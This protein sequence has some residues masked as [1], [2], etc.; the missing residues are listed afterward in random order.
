M[1]L[2]DDILNT[3]SW[4]PYG[5]MVS[6]ETEARR[7]FKFMREAIL[8][9]HVYVNKVIGFRIESGKSIRPHTG[10]YIAR[11][12]QVG[13]SYAEI[14]VNLLDKVFI[15]TYATTLSA[16][17]STGENK[18]PEVVFKD[19]EHNPVKTLYVKPEICRVL[20][21]EC[22]ITLKT[23]LT[24]GFGSIDENSHAVKS[25]YFPC[26]TDFSVS[27]FF[28]V[29]PMSEGDLLVPIRCYNGATMDDLKSI[30][31]MYTYVLKTGS[32]KEGEKEWVSSFML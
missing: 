8:D 12:V 17:L 18:L 7:V 25:E 31:T 11:H 26:Y 19:N 22:R 13:D 5:I 6:D 4:S 23:S 3:Y 16:E 14:L 1:K 32:L 20:D 30:L 27:D 28:R 9:N 21:K 15:G 2:L 29:L 24:C 10:T